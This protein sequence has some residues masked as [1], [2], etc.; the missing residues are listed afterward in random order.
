MIQNYSGMRSR[1]DADV[2]DPVRG[3][4]DCERKHGRIRRLEEQSD[5][6]TKGE[7]QRQRRGAA[8]ASR[9]F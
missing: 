1:I 6:S 5:A 7:G 3:A 8:E 9:N 2:S 4:D